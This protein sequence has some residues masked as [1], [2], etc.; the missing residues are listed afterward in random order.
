LMIIFVFLYFANDQIESMSV[1]LLCLH[2]VTSHSIV[3]T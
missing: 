3:V 1:L 2:H